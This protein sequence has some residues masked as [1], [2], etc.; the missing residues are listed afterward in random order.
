M[1]ITAKDIAEHLGGTIEGNPDTVVSSPARIEYGKSGSI[2][3]LANPKY[4]HYVYTSKAGVILVNRTFQPK[5]AVS[6]TLIR[7]DDAYKA[8]ADLLGWWSGLKKSP[9]GGNR[10]QRFFDYTVRI[11]CSARIGR[12]TRIYSQVYV[13]PRVKIG[14]GCIIYPGVKIYH[15]CTI[16]DNV[17]IH[18]NAVIGADGFGFAPCP[19][20]TYKKIPQT[21]NVVIEDNV[22]IGA[23]STVDRATMGSTVIGKGVKIDNLCQVAHN[24][25]IGDN[26]V[27]AAL[28]GIAGSSKIG[29]HC[30]IGG[31]SGV[32]GH[33]ELADN[34]TIAAR[35]GVIGNVRKEGTT[36]LGFPA[37]DPKEYMRAYAV[38]RQNG[39]SK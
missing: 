35:T 4:E 37:I 13:G 17:I 31:Q 15:D 29:R 9:R 36:L 20:G 1:K 30:V 6:A 10:L 18:A 16:G 14:R 8:V 21:G 38:F 24:V 12:G 26:T 32:I 3:F 22:E 39:K 28:S 25:E 2:C 27:M 7:V 11:A 23:N 5:Q 34:T 33:V 19:D